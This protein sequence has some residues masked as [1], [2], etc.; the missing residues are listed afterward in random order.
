MGAR[1]KYGHE[2]EMGS[3]NEATTG[4]ERAKTRGNGLC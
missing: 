2:N 1:T 4:S 3:G